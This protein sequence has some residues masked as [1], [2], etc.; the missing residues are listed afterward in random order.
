MEGGVSSY[1]DGGGNRRAG[2]IIIKCGYESGTEAGS[3]V[4]GGISGTSVRVVTT[5]NHG[6]SAVTAT[7]T[8]TAIFNEVWSVFQVRHADFSEP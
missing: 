1:Y 4:V 2:D 7:A 5:I 8:A 3:V 6:V